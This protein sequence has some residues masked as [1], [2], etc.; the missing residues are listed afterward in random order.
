MLSAYFRCVLMDEGVVESINEWFKVEEEM[1]KKER[2]SADREAYARA[3][4]KA[5]DEAKGK[6]GK[7]DEKKRQA[8]ESS[9][10]GKDAMVEEW[11]RREKEEHDR[12]ILELSER[13]SILEYKGI[14]VAQH[15]LRV[16][17]EAIEN[18]VQTVVGVGNAA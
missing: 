18:Y 8:L 4:Q 16:I 3:Y 11:I 15:V 5:W 7:M 13:R 9:Y 10:L 14:H 17:R 6:F 2:E 12:A 1:R